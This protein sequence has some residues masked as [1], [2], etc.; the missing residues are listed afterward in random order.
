LGIAVI[1]GQSIVKSPHVEVRW[2]LID[3]ESVNA[4]SSE[5]IIHGKHVFNGII[6][7]ECTVR[8]QVRRISVER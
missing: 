8:M 3:N 1:H 4:N 7:V 5:F 2:N 6:G